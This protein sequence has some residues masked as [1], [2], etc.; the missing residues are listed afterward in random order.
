MNLMLSINF[1][2]YLIVLLLSISLLIG[3]EKVI[4]LSAFS[5]KHSN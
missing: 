5:P 1:N 4:Y 2:V 3:T